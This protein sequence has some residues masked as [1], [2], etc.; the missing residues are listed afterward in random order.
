MWC[1]VVIFAV[2]VTILFIKTIEP[3]REYTEKWSIMKEIIP[4]HA[5]LVESKEYTRSYNQKVLDSYHFVIDFGTA[6]ENKVS[7]TGMEIYVDAYYSQ[8][9][10]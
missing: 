7:E 10:R 4:L 3:K 6:A 2:N 9:S 8:R 5:D 1:F